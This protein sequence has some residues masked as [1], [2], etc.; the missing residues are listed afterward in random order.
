M[1]GKH[2]ESTFKQ[3]FVIYSF[4]WAFYVHNTEKKFLIKVHVCKIKT[5]PFISFADW[6]NGHI[7]K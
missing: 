4:G 5:S 7:Y 3:T 1:N 6:S 2:S